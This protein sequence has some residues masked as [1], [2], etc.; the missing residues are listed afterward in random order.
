MTID[1]S[2]EAVGRVRR[3]VQM[4]REKPLRQVG[5]PI[6]GVH[7]GTEWEAELRLSDVAALLAHIDALTAALKEAP[8]A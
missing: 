4:R 1:T 5:E 6:H 3:Y 7:G 8:D 2:R